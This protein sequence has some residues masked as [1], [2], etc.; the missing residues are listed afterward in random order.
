MTWKLLPP[1]PGVCQSCAV[2]HDPRLPHDCKSLFYQF[3][4]YSEHKRW[5]NWNDAMAHCK[6]E[7]VMLFLAA[8]ENLGYSIVDGVMAKKDG[9]AIAAASKKGGAA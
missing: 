2:D 9:A 1:A 6:P 7:V 5:P 8:I 3:R 4:F